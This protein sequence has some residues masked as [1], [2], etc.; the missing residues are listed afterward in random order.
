MLF[1]YII[2][3]HVFQYMV[4]SYYGCSNLYV[5]TTNVKNAVHNYNKQNTKPLNDT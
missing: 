1:H 3:L 4:H 5:L 2:Y